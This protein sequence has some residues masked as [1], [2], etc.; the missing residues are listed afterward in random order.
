MSRRCD[1]ID[2]GRACAIQLPGAGARSCSTPYRRC[3]TRSANGA[4]PLALPTH[5]DP[6]PEP[7][8]HDV[9]SAQREDRWL[10]ARVGPQRS[11][12]APATVPRSRESGHLDRQAWAVISLISGS[13][14][15]SMSQIFHAGM[16]SRRGMGW[17]GSVAVE[18]VGAGARIRSYR[19]REIWLP[20]DHTAIRIADRA[21]LITYH[22]L[23]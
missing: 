3:P 5:P 7:I 17:A 21:R 12:R 20:H 14:P 19:S 4:H 10:R 23:S 8:M 2:R 1:T 11:V 9:P 16:K 18:R 13:A 6:I 15:S 22:R